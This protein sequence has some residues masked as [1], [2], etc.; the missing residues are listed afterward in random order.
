MTLTALPAI[1]VD[2]QITIAQLTDNPYAI[3]KR[4]RAEAPVV[5]IPSIRRILL[6]KAADTKRQRKL[7]AFQLG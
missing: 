5:R 3:Y 2:D 1:P 6:T 7:G 4:L